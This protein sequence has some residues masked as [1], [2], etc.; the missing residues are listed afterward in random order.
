MIEKYN[1][2]LRISANQNLMLCDIR[3][4]WRPRITQQLAAVGITVREEG[5][6]GGL[7]VRWGW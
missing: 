1:I 2:P 5:E 3:K 7:E 6:R 4:A